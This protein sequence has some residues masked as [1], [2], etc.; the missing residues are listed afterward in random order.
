MTKQ[1]GPIASLS[2]ELW[3]AL[4]KAKKTGEVL[5]L[6]SECSS[7]LEVVE[8]TAKLHADYV[9]ATEL[10]NETIHTTPAQA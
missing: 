7:S 2:G 8:L 5:D 3:R 4:V 1:E 6:Y 10:Y 9:P